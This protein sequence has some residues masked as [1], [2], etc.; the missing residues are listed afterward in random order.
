[1]GMSDWAFSCL[2]FL[3]RGKSIEDLGLELEL[4]ELCSLCSLIAA[5]SDLSSQHLVHTMG[6][7]GASQRSDRAFGCHGEGS[8]MWLSDLV[9]LSTRRK[10]IAKKDFIY[11]R[12]LLWEP[13]DVSSS[14]PGGREN[15][16]RSNTIVTVVIT[17][18]ATP[19]ST[20]FFSCCSEAGPNAA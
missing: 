11:S 9:K 10:G 5:R 17:A 4:I 15:R 7:E 16:N 20:F 1:M 2:P 3:I 8:R 12:V 6:P 13:L 14:S 18:H 19:L